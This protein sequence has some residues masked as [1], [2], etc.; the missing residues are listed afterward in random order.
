[1]GRYWILLLFLRQLSKTRRFDGFGG[2]GVL[3]F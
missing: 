3:S 1:M 2:G